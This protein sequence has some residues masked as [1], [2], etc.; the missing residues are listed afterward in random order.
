[1]AIQERSLLEGRGLSEKEISKLTDEE[2]LAL[3]IKE[4]RTRLSMA[5]KNRR[6]AIRRRRK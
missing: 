6:A 2:I 4:K 1:M 5:D 3:L